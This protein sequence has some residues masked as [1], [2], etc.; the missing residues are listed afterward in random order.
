MRPLP[1]LLVPFVLWAPIL[2]ALTAL[3]PLAAGRPALHLVTAT[4]LAVVLGRVLELLLW[5]PVAPFAEG[6]YRIVPRYPAAALLFGAMGAALVLYGFWA[7]GEEQIGAAVFAG[8][9]GLITLRSAL[10]YRRMALWEGFMVLGDDALEVHTPRE[11][12]RVP[13]FG[14]RLFKRRADGSVLLTA[15]NRELDTV[16]LSRSARGRYWVD[17]AEE[18][19]AALGERLPITTVE[20]LIDLPEGGA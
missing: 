2:L 17:N 19:V 7:A 12:Y 4:A 8:I 3:V 16:I 20:S 6:R 10:R 15:P 1:R 14:A 13:L 5:V 11:S 9:L 18:L